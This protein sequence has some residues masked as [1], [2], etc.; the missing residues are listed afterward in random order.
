M[1]PVETNGSIKSSPAISEQPVVTSARARSAGQAPRGAPG[2]RWR[3]FEASRLAGFGF[4]SRN[5]Q[6]PASAAR[7]RS[8]SNATLAID[9][10]QAVET[11]PCSAVIEE[12]NRMAAEL[13]DTLAQEFAGILLH[14]E[15]AGSLE[16]ARR[17]NL[18]EC[19][20]RARE[21][22]KSGLEDTRRMLLGLRPKSLEGVQLA[23]ALRQL[24]VRFSHDCGIDCSFSM[25]GRAQKFSDDIEN[26]L[27]RVAQEALCNVRK[28]SRARSVTIL[29][30]YK[31][32][33]VVLGIKDNGQGFVEPQHQAGAHG[34]GLPTMRDRALRLGGRM[35][36]NSAPGAGTELRMTVPLPR[37]NLDGKE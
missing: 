22:A 11:S 9:L 23:D 13:H 7:G 20:A 2:L 12:R 32:G 15:A 27:Y 1:N 36:I 8:N 30:S 10:S 6:F 17:E 19:L 31:S 16:N 5:H 29:L 28:H 24:A 3:R 18:S 25:S 14:L 26:E 35:D 37:K 34:F 21:L 4:Q 33:G